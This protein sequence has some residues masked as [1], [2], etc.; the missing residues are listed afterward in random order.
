MIFGTFIPS[1]FVRSRPISVDHDAFTLP[2]TVARDEFTPPF[3]F[4]IAHDVG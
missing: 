3:G 2:V 4:R 1:V